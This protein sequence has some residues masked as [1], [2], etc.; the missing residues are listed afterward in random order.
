MVQVMLKKTKVKKRKK[1]ST[2]VTPGTKC[3]SRDFLSAPI[4]SLWK[5]D[6]GYKSGLDQ[7]EKTVV[8]KDVAER[9][10]KLIQ[11]HNKTIS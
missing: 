11:D 3:S 5:D 4:S 6:P 10:F 2:E 1:K 9:G 7:L 8:V